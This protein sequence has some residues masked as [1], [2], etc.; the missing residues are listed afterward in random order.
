MGDA[1]LWLMQIPKALPGWCYIQ[2]KQV[3]K[4]REWID[5]G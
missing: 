2:L 3:S 5:I 4:K 1:I